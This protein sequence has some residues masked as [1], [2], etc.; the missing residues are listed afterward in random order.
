MPI[1]ERMLAS[2][3]QLTLDSHGLPF[4]LLAQV[5]PL[6]DFERVAKNAARF[7]INSRAVLAISLDDLITVKRHINRPRDREALLYLE[8]I[9]RLRDDEGTEASS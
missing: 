3:E 1:D 5:E 9:K 6:G 7:D 2:V 8:A 4:D